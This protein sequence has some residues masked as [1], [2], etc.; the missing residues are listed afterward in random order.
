MESEKGEVLYD[1]QKKLQGKDGSFG[2]C[3]GF[4][5]GDDGISG[6]GP[7]A[8]PWSSQAVRRL[9]SEPDHRESGWSRKSGGGKPGGRLREPG[10]GKPGGRL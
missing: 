10:S 2:C 7:R 5:V 9:L 4:G 1:Q 8:W 3:R 6:I